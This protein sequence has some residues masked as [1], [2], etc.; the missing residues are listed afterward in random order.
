M[1]LLY[2]KIDKIDDFFKKIQKKI[3]NF[4]KKNQKNHKKNYKK[5]SKKLQRKI[6]F[7]FKICLKKGKNLQFLGNFHENCVQKYHY[8]FV[9]WAKMLTPTP[10]CTKVPFILLCFGSLRDPP[11]PIHV[12]YFCVRPPPRCHG[13]GQKSLAC[14]LLAAPS[15]APNIK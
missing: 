7:F 9:I 6:Q 10:G 12:Q 2:R 4:N 5:K 15:T 8:T 1:V 14:T 11:H 3:K 13:W